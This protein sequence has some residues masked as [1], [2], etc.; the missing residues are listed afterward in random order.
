MF[1]QQPSTRVVR[2][3]DMY[4]HKHKRTAVSSARSDVSAH[5]C[6]HIAQ[7]GQRVKVEGDGN[8]LYRAVSEGLYG[9]PDQHPLLR[10]E[11]TEYIDANRSQF[12]YA[13]DSGPAEMHGETGTPMHYSDGTTVIQD[14]EG[15]TLT[16]MDAHGHRDSTATLQSNGCTH[17]LNKD[18]TSYMILRDGMQ[19]RMTDANGITTTAVVELSSGGTIRMSI[20]Y[21]GRSTSRTWNES[22]HDRVLELRGHPCGFTTL[23]ISADRRT[24]TYANKDLT[25]STTMQETDNVYQEVTFPDGSTHTIVKDVGGA[26]TMTHTRPGATVVQTEA[27]PAIAHAPD[28]ESTGTLDEY[29][30]EQR[31][32]GTFATEISIVALCCARGLDLTIVLED[33]NQ[34]YPCGPTKVWVLYLNG[35]HYDAIVPKDATFSPLPQSP[36]PVVAKH[37][38]C[39]RCPSTT[40]RPRAPRR[41]LKSVLSQEYAHC[42][43]RPS[44]A[45]HLA[46]DYI[47]A[48]VQGLDGWTSERLCRGYTYKRDLTTDKRS[49]YVLSDFLYDLKRGWLV[50]V[51]NNVTG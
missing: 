19:V 45:S 20:D 4:K 47:A 38:S 25:V 16:V 42:I 11:S 27:R 41:T 33:R 34:R 13:F 8:C 26:V 48:R 29:L 22:H 14:R 23:T 10:R 9:N 39:R 6:T 15:H 49:N 12:Q 37:L 36:K 28:K 50:V 3:L 35:N 2:A 40:V 30:R 1:V 5:Q 43:L 17:I 18:L 31:K 46:I 44:K 7:V 21:D 24:V 32:N 51:P